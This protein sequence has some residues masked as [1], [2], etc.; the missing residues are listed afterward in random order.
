[1]NW[2]QFEEKYKPIKNPFLEDTPYS[3]YFFETYGKELEFLKTKN[4]L[5]I[6]TLISG[7]YETDW[8]IPGYHFVDRQGYFI[9]TNPWNKE[10]EF[11]LEVD[12]NEHFTREEAIKYCKDFFDSNSIYIPTE[13]ILKIYQEENDSEITV[14]EA[15]YTAIEIYEDYFSEEFS[16]NLQDLIHDYYSQL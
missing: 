12:V 7:D 16:D 13:V 5:Q 2:E 15:K 1:M 11:T 4:E 8:I 6:W 10:E 9:T 3:G 14:G